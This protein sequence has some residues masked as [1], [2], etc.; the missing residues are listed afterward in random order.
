MLR[1]F[2]FLW[3]ILK[4]F[5]SKNARFAAYFYETDLDIFIRLKFDNENVFINFKF[6]WK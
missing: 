1:N 2:Y 4:Y 6:F 3:H 5:C